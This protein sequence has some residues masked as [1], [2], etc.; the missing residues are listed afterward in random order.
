MPGLAVGPQRQVEDDGAYKSYGPGNL[1]LAR[2]P[3]QR[4][5]DWVVGVVGA[6]ARIVEMRA[7]HGDQAPWQLRIEHSSGTTDAVLRVPTPPG[8]N[9]SMV[10]TGAAALELAERCGLLAPRLIATDLRGDETSTITTLETLV[11]GSTA[12]PAPSS[13]ERLR[14]AGAALAR[15]HAFAMEP[16]PHLPFRQRPIAV[17]DFALFRRK[18]WM[19]TTPLLQAADEVIT[20]HGLPPGDTV[21]VHGD[22]WPGNLMWAGD[23]VAA[24]IDWKTA[25]VGAPGVD[26]CELRKQV[27]MAF[28]PH[29]PEHVLQGWERAT[30][31]KARDVAYWDAVAALNTPTEVPGGAT[32]RRDAFLRAAL[33]NLGR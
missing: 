29:A 4:T 9:A 30:G 15:V 33:T 17:D 7:L 13:V 18:G 31:T 14:A 12:W 19:P 21:F 23:D 26:L 1:D 6:G 27:A 8:I 11:A 3:A 25:G 24:L 16:A 20:A 22:V 10:A 2:T 28:G 32:D 5:L